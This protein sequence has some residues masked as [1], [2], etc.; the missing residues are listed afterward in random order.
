MDPEI[1]ALEEMLDCYDFVDEYCEKFNLKS[2]SMPGKELSS[3][4][5]K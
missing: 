4:S 1:P 3:N 5:K 2:D